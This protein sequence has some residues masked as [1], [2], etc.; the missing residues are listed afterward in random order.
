VEV[1]QE[2]HPQLLHQTEVMVV[3]ELAIVQVVDLLD[4]KEELTQEEVVELFM[5][6]VL[7][8]VQLVLEDQV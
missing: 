1:E 8:H 5:V 6:V 3:V 2:I 7:L 4:F